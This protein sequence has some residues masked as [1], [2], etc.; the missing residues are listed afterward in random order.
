MAKSKL[1]TTIQTRSLRSRLPFSKTP[2]QHRIKPWS[3]NQRPS[4]KTLCRGWLAY[5]NKSL[6][7]ASKMSPNQLYQG[8][9][10]IM[11]SQRFS[12]VRRRRVSHRSPTFHSRLRREISKL[13]LTRSKICWLRRRSASKIRS[14]VRI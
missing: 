14:R 9:M 11:S 3:S 8:T 12:W 4:R 5:S 13:S 1:K 2:K 7:L 6:R 10:L